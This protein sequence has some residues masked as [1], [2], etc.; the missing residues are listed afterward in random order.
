MV[1]VTIAHPRFLLIAGI[2]LVVIAFILIAMI[3]LRSRE[4]GPSMIT[5]SMGNR[6]K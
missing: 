5:R 6:K 3:F 4:T 1:G 2:I